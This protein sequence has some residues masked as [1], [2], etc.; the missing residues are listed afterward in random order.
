MELSLTITLST[1]STL[2]FLRWKKKRM[3]EE[4]M[5]RQYQRVDWIRLCKDPESSRR[6]KEME[7]G[8]SQLTSGAPTTQEDKG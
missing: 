1:H 3:T 6:Q 5:R 8:N 7:K 4:K 2:A